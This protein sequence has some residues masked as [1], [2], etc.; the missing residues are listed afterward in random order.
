MGGWVGLKG[1]LYPALRRRVS[2]LS[3]SRSNTGYKKSISKKLHT[4]RR[5]T[6]PAD[7]AVAHAANGFE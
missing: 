7:M 5:T 4:G 1:S 3:I 6:W 2:F